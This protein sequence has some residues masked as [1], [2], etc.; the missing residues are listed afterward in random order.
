LIGATTRA[1]L[2]SAA[3]RDRFG[4][5]FHLDFYSRED[6][7]EILRRS[8]KRL[9]V[10]YD[11]DALERLAG[12]ARG[13]PRVANRLLRRTRDFAQV[14]GDGRLDVGTVDQALDI[15][16][17]DGRGLDEQDRSY[18][19]ALIRTYNG[20]P[21]GVEALAASLG[22]ERDTLEDVVEPFL[23]QIGF[24]ARTRQGRVATRAACEH[25]GLPYRETEAG[26]DAADQDTLF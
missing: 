15:L 5:V 9:E 3:M 17:I 4:L 25:L 22:Q 20:G 7:A 1:G 26:A 16:Q 6:I 19:N 24:V 18:L 13:T 14:R 2:L 23:L 11:A 21:A 8:A 12:R 10:P